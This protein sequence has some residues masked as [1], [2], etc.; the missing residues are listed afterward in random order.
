MTGCPF[1]QRALAQIFPSAGVT[2]SVR[3]VSEYWRPPALSTPSTLDAPGYKSLINSIKEACDGGDI[4][5]PTLNRLGF[6]SV[7]IATAVA[8][9]HG[10]NGGFHQFESEYKHPGNNGLQEDVE[11]LLKLR[12]DRFPGITY[13][14]LFSLVG[15]LGPELAGGPPI[16]WYPGRLDTTGPAPHNPPLSANLPDGMLNATGIQQGWESYLGLTIREQVIFLGGGHSFGGAE[17]DASGWNG[18]FTGS[19]EWPKVSGRM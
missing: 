18:S 12:S 1:S 7:Q 5:P 15:S 13:A 19:D 16:A 17:V 6:H 2:N 4:S 11:F 3:A 14:D 10:A 9:G 8:R